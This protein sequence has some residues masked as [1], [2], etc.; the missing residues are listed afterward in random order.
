M[1]DNFQIINSSKV[2][3]N[4]RESYIV[5]RGGIG[6]LRVLGVEPEWTLMTATA[7]EDHGRI[8]VCGDQ[9]R[10]IESALRLGSE[11][12]S[13]PKV[14]KDWIERE[15]VKISVI[16]RKTGQSDEAFDHEKTGLL[17]RFFEIYDGLESLSSRAAN[18][19]AE[20]YGALSPDH[21][22]GDIYLSDGMWLSSD[23]SIRDLGR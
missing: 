9:R 16:I 7:S 22:G 19:L 10:L 18:E 4:S 13:G 12:E 20:L 6:F 21:A 3:L 17:R 1:T 23:G 15:Y 14:E 2:G 11:L 8:Q 5:A